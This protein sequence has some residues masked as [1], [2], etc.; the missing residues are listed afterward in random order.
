MLPVLGRAQYLDEAVR[1]LSNGSLQSVVSPLSV[2]WERCVAGS[3]LLVSNGRLTHRATDW[4][5]TGFCAPH[6]L[7]CWQAGSD[8]NMNI[9][10]TA[11]SLVLTRCFTVY[12]TAQTQ[13]TMLQQQMTS[14]LYDKMQ[15]SQEGVVMVIMEVR[16]VC[17]CY[18][19]G[20]CSWSCGLCC[21]CSSAIVLEAPCAEAVTAM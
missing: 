19:H 5:Q 18:I 4:L 21:A 20:M 1:K 17:F 8:I 14:T 3:C 7:H 11:A 10:W 13:R 9:V 12:N 2:N 16:A 15:D 6:V